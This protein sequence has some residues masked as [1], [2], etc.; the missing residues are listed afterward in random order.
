MIKNP[1]STENT[2]RVLIYV[3]GFYVQ[4][5]PAAMQ[6]LRSV[7]QAVEASLDRGE[8]S[9]DALESSHQMTVEGHYDYDVGTPLS[10][11]Q[12]PAHVVRANLRLPFNWF[13]SANRPGLGSTTA[14]RFVTP[15]SYE[16]TVRGYDTRQWIDNR[17]TWVAAPASRHG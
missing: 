5:T 2:P 12:I 8:E 3:G 9:P 15:P 11:E 13:I 4:G 14:L 16:G 10:A 17:A 7:T 1:W 6:K